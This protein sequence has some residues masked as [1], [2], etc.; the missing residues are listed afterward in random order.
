MNPFENT[1][2]MLKAMKP[3]RAQMLLIGLVG[4]GLCLHDLGRTVHWIGMVHVL[5]LFAAAFSVVIGGGIL[6]LTLLLDL[7]ALPKVLYIN[8]KGRKKR[9]R[10]EAIQQWLEA[11]WEHP[12]RSELVREYQEKFGS[13]PCH[14]SGAKS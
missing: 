14:H 4:V 1:R 8:I 11:N 5:C 12:M 3:D 6:A 13:E 7:I 9:L 2:R 10:D